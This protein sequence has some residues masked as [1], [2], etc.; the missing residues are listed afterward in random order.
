MALAQVAGPIALALLFCSHP[1]PQEVLRGV[2][3]TLGHIPLIGTT[4]MGEYSHEGYVEGG[5]GLM[6]FQS[7]RLEFNSISRRRGWLNYRLLGKLRGIS[8]AGLGQFNH[9]TL[10][11]FP[12]NHSMNLDKVVEKAISETAMLYDIVGGAGLAASDHAPALFFNHQLIPR[13]LAGVELLSQQPIGLAL[14]NGWTPISGPYRL[15][16]ADQHRLMT[17]DGRPVQEVYEDFFSEQGYSLDDLKAQIGQFPIGLCDL[18]DCKVSMAMQ[19]FDSNGALM[20]TSPPPVG[21]LVHI[22]TTKPDMMVTAAERAIHQAIAAL[23]QTPPAGALF[24]DCMSTAMLLGT[25]YQQQQAAVRNQLGDLPFLGFRSHG[26]LA[27]LRGQTAG[28]YECSVATC[29]LPG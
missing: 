2:N 29:I 6:L 15:T 11:I 22:L 12:D 23:G 26:V 18:G 3:A 1:A 5:A 17:I 4:S 14:A 21:S 7:D 28:H 16:K 9:R 25:A 19:G 13:G 10:M 20:V 24:I 8:K 27:R